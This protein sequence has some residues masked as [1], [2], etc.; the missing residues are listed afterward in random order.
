MEEN[1]NSEEFEPCTCLKGGMYENSSGVEVV[2]E[3][4]GGIEW[5]KKSVPENKP[6]LNQI[7][8]LSKIIQ[9]D[10]A[11]GK[12][13]E[14]SNTWDTLHEGLVSEKQYKY[15]LSVYISKNRMKLNEL[16]L[17]IGFKRE[18]EKPNFLPENYHTEDEDLEEQYKAIQLGL[19]EIEEK[20]LKAKE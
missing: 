5:A 8:S 15:L 19:D 11:L 3:K 16:M 14:L 13:F 6:S 17:Q 18:M 1:I 4:C 7:S 20:I 12:H 10:E 9:A 2:C